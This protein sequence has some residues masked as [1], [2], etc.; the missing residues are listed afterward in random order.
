MF[1]ISNVHPLSHT[2]AKA[3]PAFTGPARVT[4]PAMRTKCPRSL[5]RRVDTEGRSK[6]RPGLGPRLLHTSSRK[7]H[8][9]RQTRFL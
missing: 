8:V 2:E 3:S 7:V 5:T 6:L 9:G 4:V 1:T